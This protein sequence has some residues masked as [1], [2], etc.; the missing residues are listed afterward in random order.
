MK[1]RLVLN[2]RAGDV[3]TDGKRRVRIIGGS[4]NRIQ[5]RAEGGVLFELTEKYFARRFRPTRGVS[6]YRKWGEW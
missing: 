1:D 4:A 2:L 3:W 5:L 6:R